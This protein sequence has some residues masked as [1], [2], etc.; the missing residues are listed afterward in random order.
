MT[1]QFCIEPAVRNEDNNLIIFVY[2]FKIAMLMKC[3]DNT[4]LTIASFHPW[5]E[6]DEFQW[7]KMANS[8][9]Q[10]CELSWTLSTNS[11]TFFST[12]ILLLL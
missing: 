2:D 11:W 1:T 8:H 3:E 10:N 12:R 6:V 4:K 7:T 5:V 9:E